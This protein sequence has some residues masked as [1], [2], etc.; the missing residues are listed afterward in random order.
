MF[1][2]FARIVQCFVNPSVDKHAVMPSKASPVVVKCAFNSITISNI[3]GLVTT[4]AQTP[5]RVALEDA[6]THSKIP[7]TA[8]HA[9]EHA[10][11]T[12]CVA[13]VD[14]APKT[15]R[16]APKKTDASTSKTPK[17]TADSVE[18][19]A[20]SSYHAETANAD[21]EQHDRPQ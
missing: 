10:P 1:S 9:A 4:N 17:S 13:S 2:C 3:V 12:K 5:V 18:D 8:V 21:R 6:S 19:R 20:H 14:V 16:G 15:K 11:A 7:R